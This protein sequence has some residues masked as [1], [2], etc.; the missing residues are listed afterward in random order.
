MPRILLVDD[1]RALRAVARRHLESA[2]HEVVEAEDG[3]EALAIVSSEMFDVIVTDVYM[4][5]V[6][7]MELTLRLT[8]RL[9]GAKLVVMS[10]GG[11]SDKRDVLEI[12]RRLGAVRT[13]AKPFGRD[14]LLDAVTEAL[15]SQ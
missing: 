12:A 7:G 13:V 11:Y 1:D 15:D 3:A 4:P 2:G 6:D 10:G 5:G 14:E 8:R 9:P